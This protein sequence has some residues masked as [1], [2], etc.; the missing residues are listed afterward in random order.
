MS[1]HSIKLQR[2]KMKLTKFKSI[3]LC[4]LFSTLFTSN[5]FASIS[6]ENTVIK[7]VENMTENEPNTFTEKVTRDFFSALKE[8]QDKI[9]QNPNFLKLLVKDK[10]MIYVNPKYIGS[11]ILSNYYKSFTEEERN[12]YFTVLEKYLIT[13]YA[14]VFTLY[15][16]QEI[17][18]LT[19]PYNNENIVKTKIQVVQNN[20]NPITI[21]F[22]LRKNSKTQEWQLYDITAE[23]VSFIES[24]RAEWIKYF[25]NK[26]SFQELIKYL[27]EASNQNIVFNK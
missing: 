14:Q 9:K 8:N 3:F 18:Y 5:V 7:K 16:G 13:N 22:S 15:K 23:G 11:Q 10:I 24:K 21:Y 17:N 12:Q 27:T 4:A 19:V 1:K 26:E 25:K 2:K 20:F 6:T